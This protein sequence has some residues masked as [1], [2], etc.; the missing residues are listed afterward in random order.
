[1]LANNQR[2][3]SEPLWASDGTAAAPSQLTPAGVTVTNSVQ[4]LGAD[5]VWFRAADAIFGTEP[6]ASDG[7]L[8]GTRRWVDLAPG[9]G[10]SQV[11]QMLPVARATPRGSA[12]ARASATLC[13]G[14]MA[15]PRARRR[16]LLGAQVVLQA[17]LA[18]P[19]RLELAPGV[20]L[21]L[22]R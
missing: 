12:R 20:L 10:S 13:A 17:V 19:S 4:P 22:G 6:W 9:V 3:P 7:T 5:R 2:G 14:R 1:M 15:P 11:L 16:G 18:A 8:A 21:R